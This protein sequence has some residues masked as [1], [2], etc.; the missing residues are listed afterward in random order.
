MLISATH[1][2]FSRFFYFNIKKEPDDGVWGIDDE[3][4]FRV[5]KEEGH[6]YPAGVAFSPDKMKMLVSMWGEATY[7]L[8]RTDG[9]SF[10]DAPAKIMYEDAAVAPTEGGAPA[11]APT[12]VGAPAPAPGTSGSIGGND[13]SMAMI[14][15]ACVVA[16]AV[17]AFAMS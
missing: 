9:M 2:S 15:V 8:S 14:M 5:F 16:V 17:P 12:T 3:G 13:W 6:N 4:A 11:P 10:A 7:M 1:I